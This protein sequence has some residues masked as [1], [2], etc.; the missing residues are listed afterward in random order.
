ML[1]EFKEFAL[2]GNV[3]DL[4]IGVIIGAAFSDIVGGLTEGIF[5]PIIGFLTSGVDLKAMSVLIGDVELNYGLFIDSLIK[6]IIIAF[7]LFLIVKSLNKFQKGE[8]EK[9]TSK[10]CPYCYEEIS[11]EAV[12]CPHCTADLAE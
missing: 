4:A 7:F 2:Q 5:N 10:A 11:L 3:V 9:V 1:K 8:E 12:K 6:F